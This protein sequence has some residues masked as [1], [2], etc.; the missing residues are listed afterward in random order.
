MQEQL[1]RPTSK[2]GALNCTDWGDMAAEYELE[3]LKDAG[4]DHK[5]KLETSDDPDGA[6]KE[7][8]PGLFENYPANLIHGAPWTKCVMNVWRG[9]DSRSPTLLRAHHCRWRR[10]AANPLHVHRLPHCL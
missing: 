10:Y 9:R 6:E 4:C 3:Q 1:E 5:K 7:C 8:T 2:R